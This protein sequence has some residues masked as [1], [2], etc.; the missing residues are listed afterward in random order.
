MTVRTWYFTRERIADRELSALHV[1]INAGSLRFS[2][3]TWLAR[4]CDNID[5]ATPIEVKVHDEG[6]TLIVP[7]PPVTE[8]ERAAALADQ[9]ECDDDAF[10]EHGRH[11]FEC[12]KF[13]GGAA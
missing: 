12:P 11:H 7:L 6:L 2:D 5:P 4:Y 9:C 13:D 8:D 3:L 10:L 1:D